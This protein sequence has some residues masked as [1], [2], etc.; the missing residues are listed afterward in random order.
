M[1]QC[2]FSKNNLAQQQITCIGCSSVLV[3]SSL[4]PRGTTF[5]RTD[6]QCQESETKQSVAWSREKVSEFRSLCLSSNIHPQQERFQ[7]QKGPKPARKQQNE[8]KF[9]YGLLRL[10]LYFRNQKSLFADRKRLRKEGWGSDRVLENET[11]GQLL[12]H[13][14]GSSQIIKC[15]GHA[16][17]WTK[18]RPSINYLFQEERKIGEN[19]GDRAW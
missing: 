19:R 10:I 4:M 11:G 1:V 17:A 9:P 15:Q 6:E 3:H 18:E 16:H 5:R 8:V 14:E 13:Q 12:R 2:S 7:S